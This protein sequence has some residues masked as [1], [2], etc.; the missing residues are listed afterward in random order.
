MNDDFP[1]IIMERYQT[2]SILMLSVISVF[3]HVLLYMNRIWLLV[4]PVETEVDLQ[5]LPTKCVEIQLA[6]NRTRRVS[7]V[8]QFSKDSSV[9]GSFWLVTF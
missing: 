1:L 5:L 4:M 8:V 7:N 6:I 9:L 2:C 3:H